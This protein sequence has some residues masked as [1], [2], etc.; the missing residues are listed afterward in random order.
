MHKQGDY[1][2]RIVQSDETM[3]VEF[4]ASNGSLGW[5]RLGTFDLAGSKVEVQVS[6]KSGGSV[7]Y[8]DAIRWTKES[9]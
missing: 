4:A 5:N 6:N 7:V 3:E 9:S 1:D 8:A 2:I